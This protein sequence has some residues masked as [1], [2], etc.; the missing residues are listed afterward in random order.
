MPERTDRDR[1]ADSTVH[2]HTGAPGPASAGGG[3]KGP[4]SV[5]EAVEWPIASGQILF[6]RYQVL[7]KLGEGGM[8]TVFLVRH[9]ELN[10]ERALKFISSGIAF[11]SQ[12]RERFGREAR[13]MA[14]FSHENVVVV[15]DAR[16]A[17]DSA[18]IEMEYI[19]G[20]SLNQLMRP[21][22]PMPLDWTARILEQLCD[23]LQVAHEA[24]IV[25][26]DLKPSNLMMVEGGRPGRER[27][28]V[29][30]FGLAKILGAEGGDGRTMTNGFMGT[31]QY[32]S[33]EQILE[34]PIDGRSDLYS[35]GAILYEF[36]SG[37]RAFSGPSVMLLNDT[38]YKP[39]PPLVERNPEVQ[40]PPAVEAVVLKSLAKK[41]EDR[42]QTAR[43]LW[44][45]FEAALPRS[46]VPPP[47]GGTGTGT[48][49]GSDPSAVGLARTD[50][51][52]QG[53][54][55]AARSST[56]SGLATEPDAEEHSS[57]LILEYERRMRAATPP[58]V[59]PR[60]PAPARSGDGD[61]GGSTMV[62]A[63]LA[64][65][66]VEIPAGVLD[67]REA[68]HRAG[69]RRPP[70]AAMVGGGVVAAALVGLVIVV[71]GGGF[72]PKQVTGDPN[73]TQEPGAPIFPPVAYEADSAAGKSE[74][75]WPKAL[76][77]KSDL[78]RFVLIEGGSYPRGA[79]RDDPAFGEAEKPA[80]LVEVS[81]FYLQQF[82]VT[83]DEVE[84]FFGEA[85]VDRYADDL[86]DYRAEFK[87]IVQAVGDRDRAL[88]YPAVGLSRRRAEEFA[89]WAGG[90]LPS[91]AQWEFA[92][93]SRGQ[94]RLYVWDDGPEA[95][96]ALYRDRKANVYSDDAGDSQV[97]TVPRSDP[98]ARAKA[99]PFAGDR[100]DQGV[101]DLAGNVRE[102]CRDAYQKYRA[103]EPDPDPVAAPRGAGDKYVIRGASFKSPVS[104][105]RTT[106]RDDPREFDYWDLDLG[107][108]L[109]LEIP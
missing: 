64:D 40:V 62:E 58:P 24:K 67:R 21:G 4:G 83:F 98:D 20:K 7:S 6:G 14:S 38:V 103:V 87:L 1:E 53:P 13:A 66:T 88:K 61:G 43:E 55:S 37:H 27:L 85:R 18:Y 48:G 8:G 51:G 82:E 72:G 12:I 57:T 63:P 70:V 89:R 106:C 52:T 44:E 78:S 36:L 76:V 2:G 46:Q 23:A 22:V 95:G 91:E 104:Q 101:F 97:D 73:A 9:L 39:T 74:G 47:A 54:G 42:Y 10:C 35:T 100:T 77:R 3:S 65:Q 5:V 50:P 11:D 96:D 102:W 60:T 34:D 15:H 25:H 69:R 68:D 80:H 79:F 56:P 109:V 71:I 19:R 31:P 90:L 33:P 32:A 86:R 17:G 41:P 94:E 30:D 45:A 93:R 81:D 92:A 16:L 29:L 108:R 99:G 59:A 105:A 26:R 107:F 28:K 84:A 75:G 49:Y